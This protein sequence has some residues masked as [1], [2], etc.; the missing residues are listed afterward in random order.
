MLSKLKVALSWIISL[1]DK[2]VIAGDEH[3]TGAYV[4]VLLSGHVADAL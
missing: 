3:P 1:T 4:H 2:P